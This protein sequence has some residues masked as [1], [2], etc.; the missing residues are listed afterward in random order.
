MST[1]VYLLQLQG[2]RKYVGASQDPEKALQ[3]HK[4]SGCAWTQLYP[5]ESIEAIHSSVNE[6]D[7][8]QYVLHYMNRYGAQ[9]V[10]GGSWST[11]LL[12][13]EEREKIIERVGGDGSCCIQ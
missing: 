11:V 9:N 2:G 12:S 6:S 10:R 4:E 8:D 1:H 7:L 13:H 3:Y 5:P